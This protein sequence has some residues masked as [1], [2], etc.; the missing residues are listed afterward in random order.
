MTRTARRPVGDPGPAQAMSLGHAALIV[1][2]TALLALGASVATGRWRG[3]ARDLAGGPMAMLVPAFGLMLVVLGLAPVLADG[4]R[5]VLFTASL[6]AL[7][8][9]SSSSYGSPTGSDPAGAGS[10][11]ARR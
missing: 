2:G 9:A 10:A 7:F 4:L 8:A 3:W 5:D 1:A 11:T 6:L